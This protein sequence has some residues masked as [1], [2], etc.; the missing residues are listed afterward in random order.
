V[1]D[2]SL[3]LALFGGL[4]LTLGLLSRRLKQ[5]FLSENTVA[6]FVGILAGPVAFDLIDISDWG[7]Q[8]EI[9][10]IVA[11]VTLA[12]ALMEIALRLPKREFLQHLSSYTILL[13]AL[14]P[15]M[16][17]ITGLLCWALLDIPFWLAMLVGAVLTPTDPVVASAV[18]TG[19]V[20]EKYLPTRLRDT[21]WAESGANDGLAY[22]FIALP[23]LVLGSSFSGSIGEWFLVSVLYETGFAVLLGVA[24]GYGAARILKWAELH[25]AIDATSFKT[26]TLAL[27]LTT[28][29]IS[30]LLGA[31]GLIGVFVAGVIFHLVVGKQE[32]EEV[33]PVQGAIDHFFTI[34]IFALVGIAI[35]LD[36]WLELGW[37]GVLLV[38][39]VLL[40]RR[41]PVMLL[42]AR[43]VDPLK[44]WSDALFIGWFGPLGVGALFYAVY[45]HGETG[46]DEPWIVASLVICASIVVHGLSA[47]PLTRLYGR[48]APNSGD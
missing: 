5:S 7:H 31:K 41:L 13:G 28:L 17:L 27:S 40:L 39:G 22:P 3:S 38:I 16:W 19:P 44:T 25:H 4:A 26:F 11:E 48:F 30:G 9:I 2:V 21:L 37:A 12:I 23:V 32:D 46:Y 8:D 29:G 33:E 24:I 47:T 10:R 42:V 45:A 6:L 18:V 36:D 15:L 1:S 43:W 14:M 35:P 20:A 34:P